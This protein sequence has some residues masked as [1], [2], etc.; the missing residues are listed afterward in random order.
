[1]PARSVGSSRAS[2]INLL[3]GSIH[4]GRPFLDTGCLASGLCDQEGDQRYYGGS[5]SLHEPTGLCIQGEEPS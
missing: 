4:Q 5:C 1:M 3:R 2:A